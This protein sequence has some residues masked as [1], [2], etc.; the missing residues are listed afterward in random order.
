MLR[1]L[2]KQRLGKVLRDLR[3][4]ALFKLGDGSFKGQGLQPVQEALN[5]EKVRGMVYKGQGA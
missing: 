2:G 3:E 1:A 4:P 5:R